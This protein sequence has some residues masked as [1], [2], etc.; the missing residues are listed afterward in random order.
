MRVL[1]SVYGSGFFLVG[2][3]AN[4]AERILGLERKGID[5]KEAKSLIERDQAEEQKWG[6]QCSDTFLL[7]DVFVCTTSDTERF[8]DLIFGDPF[9]ST[10]SPLLPSLI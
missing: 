7:S 1:R 3:F 5:E 10:S 9:V 8:L 4:Q 2:I 6:Q